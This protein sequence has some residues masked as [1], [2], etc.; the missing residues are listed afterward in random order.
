MVDVDHR[1]R[2]GSVSGD[3][4]DLAMHRLYD[5]AVLRVAL[6]DRTQLQHLH[7]RAGVQLE[8]V[9]HAVGEAHRV[10]GRHGVVWSQQRLKRRGAFQGLMPALLH[11]G[12]GELRRGLVPVC[13]GQVLPLERQ[14][15]VAL[16]VP[17]PSVVPQ[18]VEPVPDPLET[19]SRLVAPVGALTDVGGED[20]G[21][22][23]RGPAPHLRLQLLLGDRHVRV[24]GGGDQRHLGVHRITR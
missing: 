12:L 7:R 24:E 20:L 10:L 13:R 14:H 11:A 21:P 8:H 22:T 5:P 9:A 2:H 3:L 17:E 23:C 6:G 4:P 15:P 1:V 18:D 19:T 16:Q